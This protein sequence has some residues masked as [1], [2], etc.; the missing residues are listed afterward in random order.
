MNHASNHA[1]SLTAQ[2]MQR[3]PFARFNGPL[4]M[5]ATQ[6]DDEVGGETLEHLKAKVDELLELM[7]CAVETVP[8]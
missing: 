4:I 3:Q 6:L 2:L 5:A 1:S 8:A 7:E